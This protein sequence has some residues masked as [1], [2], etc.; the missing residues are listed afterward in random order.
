MGLIN[1]I[2]SVM[3]FNAKNV[4]TNNKVEEPSKAP[5]PAL[6]LTKGEVETIL[7]MVKDANFKGE[8][9]QKVYELV[10]KLQTYYSKLP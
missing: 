8:H 4:I 5:L 6:Q 7:M 1:K 2:K 10:L 9:V 3:A